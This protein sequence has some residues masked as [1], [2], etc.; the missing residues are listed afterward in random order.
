MTV[1]MITVFSILALVILCGRLMI[2]IVN[3]WFPLAENKTEEPTPIN[4]ETMAVLNAAIKK[5]TNAQ[6]VIEK[7]EK[8]N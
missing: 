1:G 2:G 8:L 6:G 4:S 3:K 5:I 7:V